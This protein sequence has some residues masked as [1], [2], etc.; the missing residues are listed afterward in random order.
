VCIYIYIYIAVLVFCLAAQ[1][2]LHGGGDGMAVSVDS[3][4]E[5]LLFLLV[6][7]NVWIEALD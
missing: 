2:L 6:G 7:V 1:P 5:L 3:R 4:D